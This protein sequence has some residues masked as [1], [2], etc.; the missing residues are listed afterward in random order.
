MKLNTGVNMNKNFLIVLLLITYFGFILPFMFSH[1]SNELPIL[2]VI[3]LLYILFKVFN[4]IKKE[5]Q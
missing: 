5:L 4:V 3:S 2:G 1:K